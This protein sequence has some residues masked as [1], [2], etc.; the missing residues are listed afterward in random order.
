MVF[1]VGSDKARGAY[2]LWCLGD[3]IDIFQLGCKLITLSEII[4]AFLL[5]NCTWSFRSQRF[6]RDDEWSIF[7]FFFHNLNPFCARLWLVNLE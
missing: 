2:L 7:F 5:N 3:S 1:L 6:Y 4:N